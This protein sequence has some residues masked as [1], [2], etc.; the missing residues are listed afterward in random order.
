MEFGAIETSPVLSMPK[1]WIYL[2]M[3][4]GFGLMFLNTATLIAECLLQGIDIRHASQ[5]EAQE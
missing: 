3:P 5:Q 1:T 4:V 2:A